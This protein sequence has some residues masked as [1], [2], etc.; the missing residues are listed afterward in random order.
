VISLDGAT[1]RYVER[2]LASGVLPRDEG[3]GLLKKTATYAGRTVTANPS[4][5]A[6]AHISIATGA[7]ASRTDIPANSFHPLTATFQTNFSGFGAPIG[8][9]KLEGPAPAPN[10]TGANG[11]VVQ[12]AELRTVDYTVPFGG[13][14]GTATAGFSLTAADFGPAPQSTIEQLQAAGVFFSNIVQKTSPLETVQING[15]LANTRVPCV[16]QVAALDTTDDST[17]NY[18]TL[19]FFDEGHGIQ[20]GPFQLPSTGPA[21]VKASDRRSQP[22]YFEES[23]RK[24]G[25]A[26]YVSHLAPDLSVVRFARYRANNIPRLGGPAV[27]ANV[28]DINNNVGFWLPQPDFRIPEK[29]SPGFAAFP[30]DELEAIY[31]DQVETWSDYQADVGL[32]LS[33]VRISAM[34]LR[35]STSGTISTGPRVPWCPAWARPRRTIRRSAFP[36]STARTATTL[37]YRK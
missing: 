20:P 32:P 22:F 18:D 6:T 33:W 36:T 37:N 17:V 21:Y 27:L 29:L 16:L 13:F 25:C 15:L 14:A 30:D 2:F 19:V 1:P 26:F 31:L 28:D 23:P 5:T 9:Y 11:N 34:S 8:G 24:S 35:C 12:S 4:L 10:P 3:I 7:S